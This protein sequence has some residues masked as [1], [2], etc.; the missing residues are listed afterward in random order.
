MS[1][2]LFIGFYINLDK[3]AMISQFVLENEQSEH[4]I[5]ASYVFHAII[6]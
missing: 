2:I 5:V 3:R 6:S 1:V 4:V